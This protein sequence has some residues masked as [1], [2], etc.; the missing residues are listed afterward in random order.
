MS[1]IKKR[2][3]EQELID[4]TKRFIDENGFPPTFKNLSNIDYL[5]EA[6]T[7]ERRYGGI[8]NFRKKFGFG[9]DVRK[10]EYYANQVTASLERNFVFEN[11]LIEFLKSV[12]TNQQAVVPEELYNYKKSRCRS[13]CGVYTSEGHF[14]V[15]IFFAQDIKSVNRIVDIKLKKVIKSKIKDKVYFVCSNDKISQDDL[16]LVILNKKTPLPAN[17]ELISLKN[18]KDLC[19]QMTS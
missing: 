2:W 15:D 12:F 4:G 8:V 5:P 6:K 18:F 10:T 7:F 1:R 16:G 9:A 3:T 17:V 13:D 11:I 19:S 14:F